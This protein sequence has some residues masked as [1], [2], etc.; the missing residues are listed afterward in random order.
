MVH[1]FRGYRCVG[2]AIYVNVIKGDLFD[3][4]VE[5][6]VNPVNCVGV[7]GAGL[8]LEFRSRWPHMY[9][10]YKRLCDKGDLR[11]GV[12]FPYVDG[13]GPM[14][15][16]NVPTKDDWRS[17]SKVE[18]VELGLERLVEFCTDYNVASLAMPALGCG[19]GN[20]NIYQ[21]EPVIAAAAKRMTNTEVTLVL[22]PELMRM[23]TRERMRRMTMES[24]GYAEG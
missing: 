6:I 10:E 20:L 13:N 14:W 17:P 1:R 3:Q 11:P 16:L 15:I 24:P 23:R 18:Y 7:M 5:A 22:S 21:V 8:S 9:Y 19:L 2:G 4:K 12:I